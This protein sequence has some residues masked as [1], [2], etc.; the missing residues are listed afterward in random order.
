MSGEWIAYIVLI[1]KEFYRFNTRSYKPIKPNKIITH[2]IYQH[3]DL[4]TLVNKFYFLGNR[5]PEIFEHITE[6]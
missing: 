5:S 6:K 3:L 2:I 4:K 1:D